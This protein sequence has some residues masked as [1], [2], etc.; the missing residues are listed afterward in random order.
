MKKFKQFFLSSICLL[1]AFSLVQ[2]DVIFAQGGD[3]R[4]R[5]EL[6]YWEGIT[7][8]EINALTGYVNYPDNP[9]GRSY[10]TIF[11]SLTDWNNN[12]GT[13]IRGYVH[14][15]V[16]GEYTFWIAGDDICELWLST[17]N[18]PDNKRLIASVNQKTTEREWT[19]DTAN[20]QSSPVLLTGGQKYYIEALHM[21]ST[22]SD[23]IAV[24]WQLPDGAL[25]R[26]VPGERLSPFDEINNIPEQTNVLK[27]LCTGHP[28][29]MA[30]AY[31]FARVKQLIA[32]NPTINDMYNKVKNDAKE[33]LSEA[34]AGIEPHQTFGLEVYGRS[35]LNEIEILGMV[36]Q[37]EKDADTSL[38]GQCAER[39]WLQLEAAAKLQHWHPEKFS[40]V[41]MFT[42]AS[43]IGYDWL[44][45]YLTPDQ[46]TLIRN[47]IVEKGFKAY[48]EE[49]KTTD[50]GWKGWKAYKC[51]WNLLCNGGVC[52]GALAVGDEVGEQAQEV[53]HFGLQ[54]M[55]DYGMR[56]Y[57]PDGGL[58]E[59]PGYWVFQHLFF[60]R[61]ISGVE[62]A[63]GT[64]FG[65]SDIAG[66]SET[67]YFPMY[68]TGPTNKYFNYSDGHENPSASEAMFWLSH[69]FNRPIY[70]WYHRTHFQL[71]GSPRDILWYDER[72]IKDEFV[73]LPLDKYYRGAE[74]VVMRSGWED[75]LAAFVG[76]AA[77]DNLDFIHGQ[78]DQGTFVFDALGERW[79][80][81]LGS[82]NYNLP[83]YWDRGTG[84]KR[85]TFYVLR[86]EGHNTLVI[87]PGSTQ[88]DQ[89]IWA[90][91]KITRFDDRGQN[92]FAV[93]DL[94]EAYAQNGAKSVIRGITFLNREQLLIQD[95]V[96]ADNA[97]L[98][99]FMH[100]RADIEVSNGGKSALLTQN[101]KRLMAHIVSGPAT[102]FFTVK[103]ARP[104]PSSPEPVANSGRNTR[105]VRKLSVHLD[106]VTDLRLA[107]ML[108]P[109]K[110]GQS[111]P[112]QLPEI[113][114]LADW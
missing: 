39:I 114:P 112:T 6:E 51:N 18:S 66:F 94:S 4:G 74:V 103:D 85:W 109:L 19:K 98:W 75:S 67:G 92:P 38:S 78:L 43:A 37:M 5:I 96:Q 77:T 42:M 26:P 54:N 107:V 105:N 89:Y 30:S 91:G 41:S 45:H 17:D 9:T 64:D 50:H 28:R 76:F 53:L 102:A 81:E 27:R 90:N 21:E 83:G 55:R 12:F 22:G 56:T 32:N 111:K 47:A 68:A 100:T 113:I 48:Q 20:Q 10:P 106:G 99:W 88:E 13:R 84:E 16:T 93:T 11:E 82:D 63:L 29:I 95:E 58:L 33:I 3:F 31:E 79:A 70:A 104:L 97:E 14:P 2:D 101:G 15:P 72:G 7:G 52:M 69:K 80:V 71:N 40:S 60:S 110:E 87:N 57:Y 34:F 25:E 8:S 49:I 59:T 24:G 73:K 35:W 61:F 86:A 108:V 62:T 23:N 44:Y 36:Y 46:R 1:I 65:F